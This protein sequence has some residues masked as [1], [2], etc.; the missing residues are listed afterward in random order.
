[1]VVPVVELGSPGPCVPAL[2]M[3]IGMGGDGIAIDL[4]YLW[5]LGLASTTM[6]L[7][8]PAMV[9]V[10]ADLC[11]TSKVRAG[12]ERMM[13]LNFLIRAGVLEILCIAVGTID[14]TLLV[15]VLVRLYA[16]LNTDLQTMSV[17]T[18]WLLLPDLSAWEP[19]YYG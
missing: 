6:L 4:S 8:A 13:R 17:A 9:L 16:P 3:V 2:N 10:W 12:L 7:G 14:W 11:D 15:I 18:G 5:T 1:M 19:S